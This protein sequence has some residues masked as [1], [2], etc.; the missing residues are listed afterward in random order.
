MIGRICKGFVIA[1]SREYRNVVQFTFHTFGSGGL[2]NGF[3]LQ[4]IDLRVQKGYY[5]LGL[6]LN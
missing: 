3:L 6:T 4:S 5:R 1:F 2:G